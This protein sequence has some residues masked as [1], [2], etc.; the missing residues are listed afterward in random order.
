MRVNWYKTR[1]WQ[2]MR[3]A[4]LR[5]EPLCQC[6]HHRGLD[7]NA[8]G[9]VVDHIKPH[10]GN[11]RL[12]FDVRNL[13]SMTKSCHDKL[14]QSAEKGG[15]GFDQGCDVNGEPLNKDHQWYD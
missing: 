5:R 11:K 6:P 15:K 7:V 9:E 4:Q 2:A 14:K 13:Q 12:F 1:Q 8:V 3:K 10:K